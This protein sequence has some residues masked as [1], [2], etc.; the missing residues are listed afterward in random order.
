MVS[1]PVGDPALG[2]NSGVRGQFGL[3]LPRISVL[4]DPVECPYVHVVSE[5]R[6]EN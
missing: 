5:R 3:T 1:K 2:P 4:A 6:V